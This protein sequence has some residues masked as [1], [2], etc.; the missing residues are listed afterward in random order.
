M[1]K[2]SFHKSAISDTVTDEKRQV[3]KLFTSSRSIN[4][5]WLHFFSTEDPDL[6]Y[7]SNFPFILLLSKIEILIFHKLQK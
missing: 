3:V 7:M 1:D 2:K 6:R 5:L 4:S